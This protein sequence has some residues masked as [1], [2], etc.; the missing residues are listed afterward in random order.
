MSLHIHLRLACFFIFL[1]AVSAFILTRASAQKPTVSK[2]ILPPTSFRTG[3]R[4]TYNMSFE[5]F[6]NAGY[7]EIYAVSRGKLGEK[8]AVELRSKVKT[9][10]FV[11]AAFYFLDE[12]RT[13]F[14]EATTGLPLYI[15]NIS[16]LSVLPKE[17]VNNF[18]VAQSSGY[19]WLTLIYQARNSN[20]VGNFTLQE[21][22]KT[23]SVS[24]QNAGSQHLKVAA[25]D[26]DTTVSSVTSQFFIEKGIT[27]FKI[28]FTA[29]E[30]RVPV[31]FRF[32]T[33]KGDFRVE[34][35]SIQMI[36]P[37]TAAAETTPTP[38]QTPFPQP[39]PKP[40]ATPAPY[41]E[42]EPLSADL[43][44]K[45][46][47]TLEYQ[48]STLNGQY[49]GNVTLQA[50]E[51]K[52]FTYQ[53]VGD[54]R[55]LTEDS[56]FLSATVTGTQPNQQILRLNDSISANV[57]PESLSPQQ[58]ALKF[59]GLFS[60]YNQIALFNQRTGKASISNAG[61]IDIPVGTHSILSLIYA[62]RVFNLKP[63]K[64]PN[65]PVNDTRVAVFIGND[66]Y[67]F[68]LRPSNA[69]II[70]IRNEKVSAQLI[71]VSTGNNPQIDQL[72]LRLWLSTDEKRLPLRLMLGN[73]Q[74]DLLSEKQIPPK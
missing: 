40:I 15:R 22:D 45:L 21:D 4:L 6:K 16:N 67:V 9:N 24:F 27:D 12:S 57:N 55:Q 64:D 28:N 19:D 29:D 63:S 38:V 37:D 70:N 20:G 3:E 56:L 25:G 61:Q 53:N 49:L 66:S 65:N 8:D 48:V 47:E 62:I 42:N 18:T 17:T 59:S 10:D 69:E 60:S 34:I 32:K 73:Y 2:S 71:T 43:P 5:S 26:F 68:R 13:T 39:T 30:A 14:A 46:G 33:A 58:I 11:S 36:D 35:A 72:G 51:R 50:K 44:F 31:L 41:V 7:A 23:Y 52:L 74:A 54:N 1:F